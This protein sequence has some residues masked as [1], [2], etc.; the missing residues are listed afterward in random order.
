MTTVVMAKIGVTLFDAFRVAMG[1]GVIAVVIVV[2][3][4]VQT[5]TIPSLEFCGLG[6]V[7]FLTFAM[8]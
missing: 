4:V 5:V 8:M 1:I 3:C 7:V 2:G 6:L